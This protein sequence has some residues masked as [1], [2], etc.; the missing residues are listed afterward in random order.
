MKDGR[1]RLFSVQVSL[2]ALAALALAVW[3]DPAAIPGPDLCWFRRLTGLPCPGC[4]LTRG[5]AAVLEGEFY[6]AWMLNP[7][8][9]LFVGLGG[10]LAFGPL[11]T[12]ISPWLA[13][14]DR[15]RRA[16][17]VGPPV[18]VGA[19]FVFGVIRMIHVVT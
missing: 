5:C 10:V 1:F 3:L 19:L 7:F 17:S 6:A 15:Q 14:G 11:L 16:L 4:G 8:S 9:F 2:L 18:L 12:R 13:D